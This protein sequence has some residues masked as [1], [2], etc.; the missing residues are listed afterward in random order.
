MVVG[1][2]DAGIHWLA[3]SALRRL[4]VCSPATSPEQCVGPFD[5]KRAGYVMGEGAGALVL[6]ELS[7]AERRGARIL[8]EIS[9]YAACQSRAGM[10]PDAPGMVRALR[11][12]LSDA[13]VSA[14]EVGYVA[15]DG[16]AT[17]TGDHEE[18]VAL[19]AVFGNRARDLRIGASK[20]ALGHMIGGAGAVET[21]FTVKA[22]ET[23]IAPPVV[24]FVDGDPALALDGIS[25]SCTSHRI[26]VAAKTR[27]GMGGA[28]AALVIRRFL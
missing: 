26:D 6:E 20:G 22:I 14:D 28:H 19:H 9:G 8:A 13:A 16:T 24:G 15:L 25:A 11:H 21:V 23:G 4:G 17:P 12:A 5:R 7:V 3:V 1:G 10:V 27:Y 2:T 18:A